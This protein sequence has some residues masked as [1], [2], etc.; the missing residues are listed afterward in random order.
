MYALFSDE[1]KLCMRLEMQYQDIKSKMRK[2]T[3]VSY[4]SKYQMDLQSNF[5]SA[6]CEMTVHG[7]LFTVFNI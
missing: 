5:P 7:T 3:S 1:V 6:A 4:V 2:V